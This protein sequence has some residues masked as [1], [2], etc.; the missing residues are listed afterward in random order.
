MQARAV[1][2]V[3]LIPI[4]LSVSRVPALS[5]SIDCP[6][7][8][9]CDFGRLPGFWREDEWPQWQVVDSCC[10]LED[11]VGRSLRSP[12]NFSH[13]DGVKASVLIFGDSV[14]RITLHDLCKQGT[15]ENWG[16]EANLFHS[17]RRGDLLVSRQSMIGVAPEGPYH[18]N[19][20]GTPTERIE[21]GFASHRALTGREPDAVVF[22][23]FLWD[24]QRWG[25][26]FPD[27]LQE[28]GLSAET[29][30]E[31]AA[32]LE[33]VLERSPA[34]AVHAY[35]TTVPP[36]LQDC[37]SAEGSFEAAAMGKRAH[38]LALNAVSRHLAAVQGWQAVDMEALVAPFS[39][40]EY[41]RDLHHPAKPISMTALNLILNLAYSRLGL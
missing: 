5:S 9:Q 37:Q 24:M 41:L 33:A 18:M 23:S 30:E 32:N 17:C 40:R 7:R 3:Y 39:E 28:R 25:R 36:L 8:N 15:Y 35:K 38:V 14:E 1:S 13:D 20:T 26:F 11:L 4:L 10:R 12:A 19:Y 34:A 21:N 29:I 31:W 27:K 2:V 22:S 16:H 6:P